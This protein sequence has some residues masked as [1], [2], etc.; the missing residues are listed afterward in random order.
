MDSFQKQFQAVSVPYPVDTESSEID[1]REKN[2]VSLVP[3]TVNRRG[4][5]ALL[6]VCG[7]SLQ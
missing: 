6:V 4:I 7:R 1:E 5:H 3:G 2:F